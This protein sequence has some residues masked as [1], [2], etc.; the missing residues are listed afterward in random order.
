MASDSPGLAA[1]TASHRLAS[2]Y[3]T[4][5]SWAFDLLWFAYLQAEGYGYPTSV[6]ALRTMAAR[7]PRPS[8][9]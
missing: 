1:T 6:L 5:Q 8:P 4:T 7:G 9:S 2:F 3:Q